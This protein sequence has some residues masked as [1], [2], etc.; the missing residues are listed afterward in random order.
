[1]FVVTLIPLSRSYE[2]ILCV[3]LSAMCQLRLLIRTENNV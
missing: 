2:R 1:M 3:L